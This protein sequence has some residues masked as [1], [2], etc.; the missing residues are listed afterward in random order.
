MVLPYLE[1]PKVLRSPCCNTSL[2]HCS[3]LMQ[4]LARHL[5]DCRESLLSRLIMMHIAKSTDHFAPLL[6]VSVIDVFE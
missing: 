2:G 3:P 5:Q 1:W 6:E 4:V